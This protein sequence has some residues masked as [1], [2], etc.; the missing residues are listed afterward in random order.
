MDIRGGSLESRRQTTMKSRVN[1]R[2]AVVFAVSVINQPVHWTQV[3]DVTDVG[4][5]NYG[6]KISELQK[7]HS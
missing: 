6:A 1:A 7:M 4:F 3:S 2:V 5:S